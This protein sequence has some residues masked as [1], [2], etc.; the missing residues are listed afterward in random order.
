[1][2]RLIIGMCF[3]TFLS[4]IGHALDENESPLSK[5][6]NSM[7]KASQKLLKSKPQKMLKV[8]RNEYDKDELFRN[9]INTLGAGLA[10]SAIGYCLDGQKAWRRLPSTIES[11]DALSTVSAPFFENCL[12]DVSGMIFAGAGCVTTGVAALLLIHYCIEQ[13]IEDDLEAEIKQTRLNAQAENEKSV[14][15]RFCNDGSR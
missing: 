6:L 1:M 13:L 2:N 11:S 12:K 5:A 15:I 7:E 10:M 3:V 8:L 14:V 9:G 4:C